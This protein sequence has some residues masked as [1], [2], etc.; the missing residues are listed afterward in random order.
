MLL[1]VVF[2][3]ALGFE[4][5]DFFEG[6]DFDAEAW[7]DLEGAA[8]LGDGGGLFF[9]ELLVQFDGHGCGDY[10]DVGFGGGF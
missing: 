5:A 3:E 9:A 1:C 10:L 4:F 8:E 7:G 6:G 2:F